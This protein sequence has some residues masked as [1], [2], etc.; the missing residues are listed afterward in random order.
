MNW[1]AS[2]TIEALEKQMRARYPDDRLVDWIVGDTSHAARKSD[3]NPDPTSSPPG[4]VR[5]VDVRLS[6]GAADL[7]ATAEALRGGQDPRVLYVI[8]NRRIFSSYPYM[9]GNTAWVWRPYSHADTMPHIDHVHLSVQPAGD[10]DRNPMI[11]DWDA[12]A[13]FEGRVEP[14]RGKT[15]TYA[16]AAGQPEPAETR[17]TSSRT[18]GTLDVGYEHI[19]PPGTVTDSEWAAWCEPRNIR[20]LGTEHYS[21]RGYHLDLG[22]YLRDACCLVY[23]DG[24]PIVIA[25]T[26]DRGHES[27]V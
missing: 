8:H 9:G 24:Q 22:E 2:E 4:V 25:V 15:I 27:H 14:F 1:W 12:A 7:A 13:G 10:N 17:P 26:G 11:L 23:Y 19:P 6:G 3:H 5:A 20:P 16:E 18:P 21:R